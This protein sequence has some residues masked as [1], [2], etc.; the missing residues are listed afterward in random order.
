MR[1]LVMKGM[2]TLLSS[3]VIALLVFGSSSAQVP[4]E[5]T[6]SAFMPYSASIK[7][8]AMGQ[9]RVSH[10]YEILGVMIGDS[11]DSILQNAS[12]RCVGATHIIKGAV[13]D[14]GFCVYLRPDGDKLFGTIKLNGPMGPGLKR[15]WTLDG[16]TGKFVGISGG[17]EG[18]RSLGVL[19]AAEGTAQ[20]YAKMTGRYTLP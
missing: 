6:I 14:N 13:E 11:P 9:E 12:F 18:I 19:P 3:V 10:S 20:G 4:K 2:I 16:G 7:V 8:L 17:G 1:R 5:G 15:V